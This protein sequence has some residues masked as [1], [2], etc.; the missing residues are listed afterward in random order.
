MIDERAGVPTSDCTIRM[1]DSVCKA[2][3]HSHVNNITATVLTDSS[4]LLIEL[5][6]DD[7]HVVGQYLMEEAASARLLEQ[8]KPDARRVPIF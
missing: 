8:L 7:G 5:W 3:D 1:T 4:R 6:G 2:A